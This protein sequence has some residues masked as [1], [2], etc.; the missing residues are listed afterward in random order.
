MMA[1]QD[2]QLGASAWDGYMAN[3]VADACVRSER[4]GRRVAIERPDRADLYRR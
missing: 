2:A 3:V 4:E 1:P